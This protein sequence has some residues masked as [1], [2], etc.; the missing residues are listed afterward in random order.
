[1]NRILTN[2]LYRN[3]VPL[4]SL[5]PC[6]KKRRFLSHISYTEYCHLLVYRQVRN[7]DLSFFT[8]IYITC[9]KLTPYR[10]YHIYFTSSI[11]VSFCPFDRNLLE[12]RTDIYS[13]IME[14]QLGTPLGAT[15]KQ[16]SVLRG[17]DLCGIIYIYNEHIV[18]TN[19]D[20]STEFRSIAFSGDR[21]PTERI[22]AES[23]DSF[24]FF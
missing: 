14:F 7:C 12:A 20:D 9:V 5:N 19:D 17:I 8:L 10:S 2:K 13:S 22:F 6:I 11:L 21:G 15:E 1:M 24:F 23:Y 16:P 18:I 3:K 4:S